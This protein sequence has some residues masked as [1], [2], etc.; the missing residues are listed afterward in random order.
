MSTK[1]STVFRC[2]DIPA[3]PDFPY[4]PHYAHYRGLRYAWI[5][6]TSGI[7]DVRQ[8]VAMSQ[9][10]DPPAGESVATE[11][12]LCLHGEPTWSYLYRKMIKSW[13]EDPPA[14]RTTGP[15]YLRRRVVAPDLIGFGRSDKPVEDEY[16]TWQS[17]R[18]W[19]I[20][21][22]RQ[23][24]EQREGSTPVTR[25]ALVVQDWG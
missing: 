4:S 23:H 9:P 10:H 2:N 6:E 12:I 16:Y 20:E 15:R 19:L 21:F 5:D 7:F 8:G 11:T 17:H 25:S 1:P 13:L 14:R 24:V 3:L 18:D 22:V